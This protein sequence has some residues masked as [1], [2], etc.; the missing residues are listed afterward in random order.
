MKN[1][2]KKMMIAGMLVLTPFVVVDSTIIALLL[3]LIQ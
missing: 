3:S 2:F 1:T